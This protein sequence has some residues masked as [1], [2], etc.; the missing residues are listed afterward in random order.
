[1]R[2]NRISR[3]KDHLEVQTK[4]RVRKEQNVILY[5]INL[6]WPAILSCLNAYTLL[7]FGVN[8][9]LKGILMITLAFT[10]LLAAIIS[11]LLLAPWKEVLKLYFQTD[12]LVPILIAS[13]IAFN[14]FLD[15]VTTGAWYEQCYAIAFPIW[16]IYNAGILRVMLV[17][18]NW[19]K[20]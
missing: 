18:C 14:S 1:M 2:E 15:F 5:F 9:E 12:S 8:S 4:G 7:K 11:S 3:I 20:W 17:Y 13:I 10:G 16:V 6:S 19:S